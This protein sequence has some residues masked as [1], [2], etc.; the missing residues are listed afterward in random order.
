MNWENNDNKIK[1]VEIIWKVG[2]MFN[3]L[4]EGGDA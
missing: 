2:K 4:K 3:K 1:G